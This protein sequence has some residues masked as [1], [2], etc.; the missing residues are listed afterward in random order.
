[1]WFMFI[2]EGSVFERKNW[3][4]TAANALALVVGV[5]VLGLGT[6]AA[7]QDIVSVFSC[8]LLWLPSLPAVTDSSLDE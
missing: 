3:L 4:L 7:V 2:R 5:V 1:M 8:R 6:Y